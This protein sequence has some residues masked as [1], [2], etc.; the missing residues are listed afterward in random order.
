MG[1]TEFG[2]YRGDCDNVSA[3]WGREEGGEEGAQG[4]EGGVEVGV[5]GGCDVIE[6]SAEE[7]VSLG[8][9]GGIVYKDCGGEMELRCDG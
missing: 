2:E 6:G 4:V 7:S 8:R 9:I 5:Q 1:G 3:N